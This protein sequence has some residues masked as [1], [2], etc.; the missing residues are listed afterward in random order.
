MKRI[1]DIIKIYLLSEIEHGTMY[2]NY[3]NILNTMSIIYVAIVFL[4]RNS[5]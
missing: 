2:D 3:E 1:H 5:S 4:V